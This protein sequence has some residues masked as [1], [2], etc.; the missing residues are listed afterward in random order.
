MN[1]FHN[2][3]LKGIVSKLQH[4][5]QNKLRYE[6]LFL[7]CYFIINATI[8]ATSV[9][10][11]AQRKSDNL[12]FELWEPF[13]WEYTSALSTLMLFPCII[14]FLNKAPLNWQKIKQ[15]LAIY[16]AASSLFSVSHVAIMVALRKLIY[17]SQAGSYDFG[18]IAYEMLYEY[19]KDLWAFIF[20][21]AAIHA[22]RFILSRLYGEANPI[23]EGE[24]E[25]TTD[26]PVSIE[27]LLVKK[28]GK[29]FIINVTDV[30]WMESSGN[31]VNLYI[32]DRIYPLRSTL[33]KLSEQLIDKGFCR[34]HR[35]HAVKLDAI[36]S[37]TPLSSGDSEI[38]LKSGKVLN[39]SRRYKEHF[40]L[41]L[42]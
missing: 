9:V 22:Y 11:E 28:L 27:R 8:L 17:L 3:G 38:K 2:K 18:N 37:I 41:S 39:L 32:N 13:I 35:S 15:S 7:V 24:E 5:Q 26:A 19:R 33:G 4:F 34:I 25:K 36:E 23:Q 16:F 12:P 30:E 20:F 29:E 14:F 21:V 6:I 31:Y 10:M 42:T 40:K 1:R